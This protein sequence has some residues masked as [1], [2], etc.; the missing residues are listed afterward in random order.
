[1]L[2]PSS[3][4]W[5][6]TSFLTPPPGFLQC[7]PC[8]LSQVLVWGVRCAQWPPMASVWGAGTPPTLMEGG[9]RLVEGWSL[10]A[11]TL[12]PGTSRDWEGEGQEGPYM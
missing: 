2:S 10:D 7:T 9:A 4:L 8:G 11:L 5:G 3:Q 1:M 12:P 6:D